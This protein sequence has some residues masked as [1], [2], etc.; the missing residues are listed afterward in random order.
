MQFNKP[1]VRDIAIPV[2]I[3]KIYRIKLVFECDSGE[4]CDDVDAIIRG[5]TEGIDRCL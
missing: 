3:G 5:C 2:G 4:L 1:E